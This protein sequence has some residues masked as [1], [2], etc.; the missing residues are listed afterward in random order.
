MGY[1]AEFAKFIHQ[2]PK[3]YDTSSLSLIDIHCKGISRSFSFYIL[4]DLGT[5]SQG[6]A[7]CLK[8]AP[9]HLFLP[10]QFYKFSNSVPM[11][12][13]ENIFLPYQLCL[14]SNSGKIVLD[15]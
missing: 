15:G 14:S 7:I 8:R 12:D 4:G 11:I 9:G 13:Q 10:N 1:D 6:D 2:L 3:Q 5:A